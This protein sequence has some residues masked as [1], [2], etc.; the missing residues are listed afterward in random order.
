MPDN[1]LCSL[2]SRW[3]W[4]SIDFFL[5]LLSTILRD[6][7]VYLVPFFSA[8]LT[9]LLSSKSFLFLFTVFLLPLM[10]LVGVKFVKLFCHIIFLSRQI[11]RLATISFQF[12]FLPKLPYISHVLCYSKYCSGTKSQLLQVFKVT[13][14]SL[15]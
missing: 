5:F 4:F 7:T 11:Q 3:L 2:R 6:K 10:Y 13:Q 9:R 14:H 8:H 1:H 15:T 12:I